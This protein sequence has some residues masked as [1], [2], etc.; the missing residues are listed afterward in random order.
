MLR[1][2]HPFVVFDL[3]TRPHVA[4]VP[5]GVAKIRVP[6]AGT[7]RKLTVDGFFGMNSSWR[8]KAAIKATLKRLQGRVD[9]LLYGFGPADLAATLRALGVSAGD[10]VL[11]HSSYDAFRAFRGRPSDVIETLQRL[12]GRKGAI[13]MPT[14]PFSGTAV[15]WARAHPTVD[16]RRTPS[17]MGLVS[18]I[19]RRTPDVVRS[20]HPTHPVAAWGDRAESLTAEHWRATTPCGVGSPYH[21]L[22]ECDGRILFL[23]ADVTSLTFFHTAE[24]LL[25]DRWPESP[26]THET[27]RLTTIARDGTARIT[28]TH[29]FD[30]AVSRRRNLEKLLPELRAREAW[31]QARVGRLAVAMV[32]AR[33]V[34]DAV[35]SL[36]ARG[37]Y[38]YDEPLATG[39]R[40]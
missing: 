34:L 1:F 21:R 12:V 23:G 27:F 16:L 6:A 18:E 29:L 14:M 19:F 38:A 11:V 39:Q 40:R 26:F 17:R 28:Q 5:S 25:G 20:V 3:F 24:A 7:T 32:G 8:L 4:S 33:D 35:A 9:H 13:L 30:P 10:V 22:L 36:A 2:S 15:E 31:R 37:I